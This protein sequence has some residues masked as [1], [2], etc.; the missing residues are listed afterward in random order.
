MSVRQV[1]S[2]T[3][4]HIHSLDSVSQQP[5]R[6]A[7][8]AAEDSAFPC[9]SQIPITWLIVF[10]CCQT[11]SLF[12]LSLFHFVFAKCCCD[13]T[14]CQAVTLCLIPFCFDPCIPVMF[15][16]SLILFAANLTSFLPEADC[17]LH[18]GFVCL[19][20]ENKT[21]CFYILLS[22]GSVTISCYD[23]C[24]KSYKQSFPQLT[25]FF[26]S[27]EINKKTWRGEKKKTLVTLAG[28]LLLQSTENGDSFGR[29][30][31]NAA[32]QNTSPYQ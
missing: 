20:T 30:Q 5:Q 16:L 19:W 22:P 1:I 12:K 9:T 25:L 27:L 21:P 11:L 2:V 32:L 7:I 8:M 31:I 13:C 14:R 18:F 3:S 23:L 6:T 26:L 10:T 15:L 4:T 24:Y 17:G 28:N 29:L